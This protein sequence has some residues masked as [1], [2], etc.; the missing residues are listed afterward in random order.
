MDAFF[1]AVKRVV[2]VPMDQAHSTGTKNSS[3]LICYG[4]IVKSLIR[5]GEIV[6]TCLPKKY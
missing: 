3:T 4:K 5:S 2:T 1:I 6:G